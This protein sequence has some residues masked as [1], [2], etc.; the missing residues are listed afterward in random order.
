MK[1]L[2]VFGTFVAVLFLAGCSAQ[3][4]LTRALDKDPNIITIKSDSTHTI[5]TIYE[6]VLVPVHD[7]IPITI[8]SDTIIFDAK[9]IDTII[10]AQSND[11]IAHAKISINKD[12]FHAEVW[13]TYDTLVY[14]Q[15]SVQMLQMKLLELMKINNQAEVIIT[16]KEPF[17]KQLERI[18]VLVICVLVLLVIIRWFIKS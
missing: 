7:T 13:A 6:Q 1:K 9:I 5:D 16:E 4:L 8:V 14:W 2:F 18:S 3:N 11:G 17:L 12:N 15:D 10:K